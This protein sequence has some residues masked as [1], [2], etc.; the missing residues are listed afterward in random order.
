M[1]VVNLT[2]TIHEDDLYNT[3]STV[4]DLTNII[5]L[6]ENQEDVPS[7]PVPLPSS[8]N[9]TRLYCWTH[10]GGGGLSTELLDFEFIEKCYETVL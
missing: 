2:A 10:P 6:D 5:E 9:L 7:L 8:K 1:N 3:D 4:E